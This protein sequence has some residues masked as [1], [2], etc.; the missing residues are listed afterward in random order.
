MATAHLHLLIDANKSEA[1]L[2][3]EC[4]A[5]GAIAFEGVD[6]AWAKRF[7]VCECGIR[8][9]VIAEQLRQLRILAADYQ[10]RIDHLIGTN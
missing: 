1:E 7:I 5:C 3:A 6:S 8:I 9:E 2:M 4:P 10:R